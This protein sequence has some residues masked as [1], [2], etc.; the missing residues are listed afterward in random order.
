M[1]YAAFSL[2][3]SNM[4]G[5]LFNIFPGNRKREPAIDLSL[6]YERLD[7]FK[8]LLKQEKYQTFEKEYEEL[9]WDAKTLLNEGIGLNPVFESIIDKW[10]SKRPDSYIARLFTG[11]S[12]TSRAWVV[13]TAAL[14][15]D[16]PDEK[17]EAFFELLEAAAGQLQIA[18]ELNEEDPEICAR[19]I[20]VYMGLSVEKEKVM[21]YF[22][23][24]CEFEPHH[25][26]AH[27]MMINYLSPKWHGSIEEMHAF[28]S[29]RLS[30]TDNS[31]LVVLPLF[32][33]TEEW[34]YYSITGEEE[35]FNSFFKDSELKNKVVEMYEG[36]IENDEGSLLLAY[37]YNYFGFLFY[38]LGEHETARKIIAKTKGKITIFPWTYID[39]KNTEELMNL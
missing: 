33:I 29:N 20:R 1:A 17:A 6:G 4:F 23:A 22:T 35:K 39:V 31:L 19:T 11:V 34:L 16:V 18:D 2:M 30:E 10:V 27:L 21:S 36:F 28:A 38:M 15:K 3:Q 14:G 5:K 8:E 9:N 37:V 24:A 13:R 32:A 26:M 25:L 12:L 7:E